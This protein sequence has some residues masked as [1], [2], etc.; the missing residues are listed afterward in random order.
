MQR[1]VCDDFKLL[2]SPNVNLFTFILFQC[3][4]KRK[5]TLIPDLIFVTSLTKEKR[6]TLALLMRLSEFSN[7][8]EPSV[9]NYLHF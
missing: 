9:I 2:L 1:S 3:A 6:L 7:I 8:Q 5:Q 4:R